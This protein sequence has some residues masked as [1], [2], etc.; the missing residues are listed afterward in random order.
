MEKIFSYEKYSVINNDRNYAVFSLIPPHTH[1]P[2]GA[3]IESQMH[4][5]KPYYNHI[6]AHN[7]NQ[8]E[9]QIL[10]LR[11]TFVRSQLDSFYSFYSFNVTIAEA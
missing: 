7:P 6:L 8:E 11:L 5:L 3:L 2:F 10:S 1:S 4:K 9:R